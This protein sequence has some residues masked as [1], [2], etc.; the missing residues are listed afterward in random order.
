MSLA[1]LNVPEEAIP[2]MAES[3][4]KITRLL[5]NNPREITLPDAVKL[6]FAA[7]EGK[8]I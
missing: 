8:R 4:M 1:E 3:V 2:Q 6:Y 5:S 7:Y